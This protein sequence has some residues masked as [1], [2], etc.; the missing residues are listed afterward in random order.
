MKYN[1][2]DYTIDPVTIHKVGGYN[3]TSDIP[4]AEAGMGRLVAETVNDIASLGEEVLVALAKF[5][6]CEATPEA[7][8]EKFNPT[9]KSDV[10]STETEKKTLPKR[11]KKTTSETVA[12]ETGEIKE[13]KNMAKGKKAAPKKKVAAKKKAASKKAVNK[14]PRKTSGEPRGEKIL[15]VKKLLMSSKGTTT[16]EVLEK[17]GWKAVN[18]HAMARH[19]KV[20][21]TPKKEQG[22]PTRYF[23]S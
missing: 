13:G 16:R 4:E 15:L 3:Q 17:T 18:M 10:S 1:V 22:K 12:G 23:G 2:I 7:I 5:K 21:L 8:W 6:A 14:T 11:A 20:K 19:A 9:P